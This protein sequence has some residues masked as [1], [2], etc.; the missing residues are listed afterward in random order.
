MI[1]VV[2][3]L[4]FLIALEVLPGDV[5]PWVKWAIVTLL[6]AYPYCK[7]TSDVSLYQENIF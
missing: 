5:N 6:V 3:V 7:S 2:W 4:P 1:A